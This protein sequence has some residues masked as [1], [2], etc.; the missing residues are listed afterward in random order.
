MLLDS[1]ALLDS[2][3]DR[4]GLGYLAVL[5]MSATLD[6]LDHQDSRVREDRQVRLVPETRGLSSSLLPEA[7]ALDIYYRLAFESAITGLS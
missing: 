1:R 2:L 3:V 4:D 6:R 5:E 7:R